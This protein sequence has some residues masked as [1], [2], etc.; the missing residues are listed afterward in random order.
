LAASA[1]EKAKSFACYAVIQHTVTNTRSEDSMISSVIALMA[2]GLAAA[3]DGGG[4]S[5]QTPAATTAPP[6]APSAKDPSKVVCRYIVP[7]GQRLG[8]ER[9]C[10]TNAEWAEVNRSARD[11]VSEIQQRGGQSGVPGQ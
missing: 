8:G 9:V 1:P 7:T 4:S 5:A 2:A 10:K 6:A 3:S 11:S